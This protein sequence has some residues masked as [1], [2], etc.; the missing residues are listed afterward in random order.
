TWA[1]TTNVLDGGPGNDTL[2]GSFGNDTYI[3]NPGDGDD[4]L[5]ERRQGEAYSNIDPS[6]DTLRFGEGIALDDLEFIRSGDDLQIR[7]ENGTDRITVSN[8]FRES[9][10]H[11]K[12]NTFEFSD[13]TSLTDADVEAAMVTMGTSGDDTMLGYR[14]LDEVVLAGDG[15]DEVWGRTGNDEIYGEAGEDYLDGEEGDD[16]LF[17]GAGKD[18]LVGRAGDDY[19][20]GG[21]GDDTLQGGADNDE[22]LGQA[23][24]DTLFGGTGDD[25]L[26]GGSEDDY[27]EGGAGDDTLMGG[28]GNDQLGGGTGNDTLLGGPGDDMYVY[29]DGDGHDVID[30]TGGGNDG[31]FFSN[32]LTE[33]RL[34]FT[35]E[36]QDLLI[37][38]DDGSDAS[39]RVENHFDGGD[40]AIGW[41]QP[42][43]GYMIPTD[44]I[45]QMITDG[46]TEGDGGSSDD[47]GSGDSGD[48]SGSGTG[49]SGDE[50]DTTPQLGDNDTITG[51][52]GN[53]ILI[54]GAGDDVLSGQG[55]NDLLIGGRGNDTYNFA[56]GGGRD[57]INNLSNG[58]DTDTLRFK[59][60]IDEQDL[61][62]SARD[63]DLLIHVLG[64]NDQVR[65][66][67]W[68]NDPAQTLDAVETEGAIIDSGQLEQLVTA[69]AAFDAPANGEINLTEDQQDQVN[70]AIAASWQAA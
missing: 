34:A 45:N 43:D 54:G 28:S 66:Q 59:Q 55:G 10:N 47:D 18:N 15:D 44:Q 7:H 24:E 68:Y 38:V 23:G 42:E 63:N 2:Y 50:E 5:I 48:D 16:R 11:Y 57:T 35:R 64:S 30:N 53:E 69:M 17:G 36:G 46:G 22:L 52:S 21:E 1:D 26:D 8:W 29:A 25:V 32:G 6:S 60:S 33:D 9:T 70:A 37:L 3:F 67:D 49:E 12:V 13:G 61:W 51:T 40:A 58:N 62:F 20:E 4:M 14:D 65:V 39:I 56:S 27:L 41:V 19:L 31:I